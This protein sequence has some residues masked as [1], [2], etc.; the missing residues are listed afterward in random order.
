VRQFWLPISALTI[1]LVCETSSVAQL[2][3]YIALQETKQQAE[4]TAPDQK[5]MVSVS[6]GRIRLGVRDWPLAGD[7]EAKYILVEMFDY[8]CT[9]CRNTHE[10]IQGAFDRFGDDF[11]LIA[12]AVPLDR[13]CN[14]TVR[15]TA[16]HAAQACELA[17]LSVAVWRVDPKKFREFHDWMFTGTATPTYA[18]ARREAERMVGSE[19]LTKELDKTMAAKYI[20]RHVDMYKR[21]GSGT[22]P[23][24]LFPRSAIVGEITSG[25]DLSDMIERELK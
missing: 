6:G 4:A 15:R 7:P 5:R 25:R 20:A 12:L 17:K 1:L 11:A 3:S 24:L 9:H 8:T 23:K 14:D 18:S 19:A 16:D 22:I 21:V 10:A 13:A 2:G